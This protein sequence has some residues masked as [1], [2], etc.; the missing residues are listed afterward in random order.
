VL[1]RSNNSLEGILEEE[2]KEYSQLKENPHEIFFLCIPA[3]M[4]H[5]NKVLGKNH[6]Y[7]KDVLKKIVTPKSMKYMKDDPIRSQSLS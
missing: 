6:N 7:P 4:K 5:L 3:L 2:R 1:E